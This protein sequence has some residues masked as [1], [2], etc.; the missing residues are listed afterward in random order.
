MADTQNETQLLQAKETIVGIRKRVVA[1]QKSL[2]EYIKYVVQWQNDTSRNASFLQGCVPA[3]SSTSNDI[4]V[5]AKNQTDLSD[6]VRQ[7]LVNMYM[8]AV[9]NPVDEWLDA[10]KPMKSILTEYY[11][12]RKSRDHYMGKIAK[13]RNKIAKG[14]LKPE[15]LQ[16][17]ERKLAAALAEYKRLETY[18]IAQLMD[19]YRKCDLNFV[20]VVARQAQFQERLARE[21]MGIYKGYPS[22][23]SKII[24]TAKAESRNKS[25]NDALAIAAG[26]K[27]QLTDSMGSAMD[28][29]GATTMGAAAAAKSQAASI[30]A[31][32]QAK[33]AKKNS[34]GSSKSASSENISGDQDDWGE[35][36]RSDGVGNARPKSTGSLASDW[37]NDSSPAAT[38]PPAESFG[39]WP[40]EMENGETGDPFVSPPQQSAPVPNAE[41]PFPA[42]SAPPLQP[43]QV[44]QTQPETV[45]QAQEKPETAGESGNPFLDFF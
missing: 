4:S 1:L 30:A 41:N 37:T 21:T 29:V 28:R 25:G 31:L 33:L 42:P 7:K 32:A 9:Q 23:A 24:D 20:T 45:Q 17:N 16:R 43:Q 8:T 11:E 36:W 35:D 14:K 22:F 40:D 39:S 34:K 12:A 18:S 3:S 6:T 13:L 26:A 19:F 44:A 27:Q 5:W 15:I 38:R 2:K 10:F